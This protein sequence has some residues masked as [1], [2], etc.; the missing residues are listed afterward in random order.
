M[1]MRLAVLPG[2]GIGPE[3]MAE[4]Q[5]VLEAVAERAGHT[6]EYRTG[7]VGA[8]SL[9]KTGEP[10]TKEVLSMCGECDAILFGAIGDPK[11]DTAPAHQRPEK[12]L[13][14][15]RKEFGCFANLRPVR[16]FPALRSISVLRP[17]IVESGVDILI[18]RELTGGLYY[19]TPRGRV[20]ENGM[21]AAVDTMHYTEEEIVRVARVAFE[22]AR[23]RRHKV[24]SVDKAN[25][26]ATSQLWRE[27]VVRVAQ[28]Y[29]DVTLEHQLV[30][31]MAMKLITA[32]SNYDV[33]LTENMFGDI[34]SD[35][36]AVLAGSL[37]ML[38]SGTIS[39]APPSFFEPVHGSA[40][41]IAG[42]GKANPL[43]MILTVAMMLRYA[44]NLQS[45]A[46]SIE[47]AV[48]SVLDQGYRTADI[49]GA[50]GSA[51]EVKM[52]TTSQMGDLVVAALR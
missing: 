11:W 10:I 43:G 45:E 33:V 7:L 35:E 16:L 29:P 19:G 20:D 27:L 51:Q 24:T 30:D 23:K 38:P 41:D 9:D 8:A 50:R 28:D 46:Q 48:N 42:Q 40:P 4:A 39:L 18:I 21:T 5:K 44:F 49:A 2:D 52:A 32:P 25:I 3:V 1:K 26:L 22:A 36:A 34:L 47:D 37:G 15:L 6:L 12:A 14:Q 13:L 17:D 31:S